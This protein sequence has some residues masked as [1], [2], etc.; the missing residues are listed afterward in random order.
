MARVKIGVSITGVD[1][2]KA[3]LAG[4]GRQ[5][6]FAAAN[7]INA[8]GKKVADEMPTRIDAAIDKPTPFTRRGVRVLKYANK[9]RLEATV[10]FMAAQAKY[11]KWAT[12]GGVRDPGAAGLRIPAAIKLNEFGNIPRGIIAQLISVARKERKLGKVKARRIAVSRDV[13]LFYGDPTDQTGKPWP[14]GIYKQVKTGGRSQL[15]PLVIF[16]V[17]RAIYRQRLDFPTIASGIIRREWD[18]TFD[19]ELAA[20]L[21]TAR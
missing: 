4:M 21:R 7:A 9:S 6:A 1:A 20:A 19:G 10:G 14:R 15:I 8:V 18:R 17:K 12:D 11:M 3:Q 16:P 2:V 13:E 5:V